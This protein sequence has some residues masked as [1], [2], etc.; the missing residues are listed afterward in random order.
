MRFGHLVLSG[1]FALILGAPPHIAQAQ[2]AD[3]VAPTASVP[4][5]TAAPAITAAPTADR[6][7]FE[8]ILAARVLRV[9][10]NQLVP[11]AMKGKDGNLVGAD[12]DVANRLA[13]DMGLTPEFRLYEWDQLIP[14]LQRGEIDLISA[15]LSIT[16]E[17]ALQVYF[18]N[19]Y[20][21]SGIGIA[22]NIKLT[23]GF[24]SLE[25]LDSP[26]VAIGVI[27]G[28]VS[29]QL[30][31]ELFERASIKV[32]PAEAQ[33]EEA[34]VKGLLHAYVRSEP[35]PRFLALRHPK[36]VD[37]PLSKPLL[38]TRE[39]FAVRRGDNEFINF[40]NAW[41]VTREADAWLGSTRKYWFENLGWQDKVAP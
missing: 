23:S 6:R 26:D 8:Q 40:L 37:V 1:L 18:S 16:P 9:G 7:G 41:I 14:A 39:A 30:A 24:E 5:A 27:G 21:S 29:E 22:T 25:N 31:R 15:G 10:I 28:T 36:E 32:F 4:A 17:R 38:A 35:A 13:K 19:P 33:A 3:A 11:Y 20:A 12:I 2:P 34:L